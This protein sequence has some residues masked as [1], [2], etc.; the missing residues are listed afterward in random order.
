MDGASVIE[1]GDVL[2]MKVPP[3]CRARDEGGGVELSDRIDAQAARVGH[4]QHDVGREDL[5]AATPRRPWRR[6]A[7]PY[8]RPSPW[9][10][11]SALQTEP[12]GGRATR[13]R[14]SRRPPQRQRAQAELPAPLDH[15]GDIAAQLV[16]GD[17]AVPLL[18]ADAHLHAGEMGPGGS[19]AARRRRTGGCSSRSMMISSGR[20]KCSGSYITAGSSSITISPAFIWAPWKSTSRLSLRPPSPAG[21]PG[22]PP[23]R[24]R[25]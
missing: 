20:S 5:V 13:G 14:R 21:R 1:V 19:G 8:G 2:T 25:G 6:N 10:P 23:R 22:A 7:R 9:R 24:R 16:V 17:P 18:E 11:R 4:A 12:R 3:G 15:V